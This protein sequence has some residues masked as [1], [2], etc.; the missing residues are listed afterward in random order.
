MS[1]SAFEAELGA[2]KGQCSRWETSDRP[3]RGWRKYRERAAQR[4]PDN[5]AGLPNE[6]DWPKEKAP[7]S[8]EKAPQQ[9][10]EEPKPDVSISTNQISP[11]AKSESTRGVSHL[12]SLEEFESRLASLE[13]AGTTH[14]LSSLYDECKCLFLGLRIASEHASEGRKSCEEDLRVNKAAVTSGELRPDQESESLDQ[15]DVAERGIQSF[16]QKERFLGSL[17]ER[18][19]QV[20]HRIQEAIRSKN[21]ARKA[22]LT[23]SESRMIHGG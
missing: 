14:E 4:W 18:L 19:E 13:A 7:K 8:S 20:G 22:R 10:Q 6:N 9:T 16:E 1:Q 11:L 3:P 17:L 5:A 23:S 21:A 12:E 15:V 2:S